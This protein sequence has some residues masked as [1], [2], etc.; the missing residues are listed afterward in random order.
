[1]LRNANALN[2][3]ALPVENAIALRCFGMRW[4]GRIGV[5]PQQTSRF[6]CFS[7]QSTLLARA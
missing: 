4:R 7:L 3:N 1:L 5:F 6:A 2:S